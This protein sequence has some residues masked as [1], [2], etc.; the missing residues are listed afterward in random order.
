MRRLTGWQTG[1]SVAIGCETSWK[2]AAEL[3][4]G[5]SYTRGPEWQIPSTALDLPSRREQIRLGA[6]VAQSENSTNNTQNRV[7]YALGLLAVESDL[8][9]LGFHD[10]DSA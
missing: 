6:N 1:H 3:G 5:P 10:R 8:G 7:H 9:N 2:K 4:R